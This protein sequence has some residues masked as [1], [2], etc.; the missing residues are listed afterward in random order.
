MR[1][2]NA[3]FQPLRDRNIGIVIHDER[4]QNV[5]H[6]HEDIPR[7]EAMA[8]KGKATHVCSG[9]E[10]SQAEV[11]NVISRVALA[12]RA[13]RERERILK[14]GTERRGECLQAEAGNV[15][16]K[17]ALAQRARRERERILKQGTTRL[18]PTPIGQI[19]P[20]DICSDDELNMP[21]GLGVPA[22]IQIDARRHYLGKM[23]IECPHCPDRI[24]TCAQVDNLVCAEFPNPSDDP[25][26]SKPSSLV[27]YMDHAVLEIQKQCVWKMESVL[28]DTLETSQNQLPW[29]KMVIPSIVVDT[30][31]K[32]LLEDDE[33]WVQCLEE[34][35]VIKIGYQLRRLFSVILTQCSPQ[36][37]MELWKRFWVHICDDLGHKIRTLFS[38]SNPTEAQIEDYGL[39]LLNQ[40]LQESGKSLLDFPPMQQPNANWSEVTG[41]RFIIEHRQLQIQAQ[42]IDSQPNIE[43]LN[44]GQR[45][46]YDAILT[47]VLDNKGTTFFMSGGAGTGKIFVHNTVA[48]KCRSFGHIVVT[49]AS[50]GIAFLLLEGGRTTH[51]TFCIPLDVY[52]NSGC[53]FSKQ[54]LQAELFRETKLII[55]DEVSMQHKHCVEAVDRTLQD[56][57][58]NEK[59]LGGITVVRPVLHVSSVVP[60]GVREDIVNASLR[61]SALWNDMR[62]LTLDLN[63]RL[64]IA[65]P[66][67]ATFA[68]FLMEVG[69]KPQEVVQLPTDIRKCQDL[70]EMLS[71]VYPQLN[72]SSTSTPT[73]LTERIILS[74]RN[75]DVNSINGAALN[76]YPGSVYT[77]LA[78][79]KMCED[80]EIDGSITN[81]YP[82]EYLNSLDPPGLP[83]FKLELKVGSP[84]ILLRNIA[85]KDGLCNG[86]RMMVVRC[87]SRI[88]ELIQPTEMLKLL[89][90]AIL[91]EFA[92][93][94]LD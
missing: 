38:I 55:W 29:M 92:I 46:A 26:L 47:S 34:A 10:N 41:N 51:S 60:K 71:A 54:S 9:K 80:D 89:G 13:R 19:H 73:F 42:R 83:P 53:G 23:D 16:S 4:D 69:T 90:T 93:C 70:N 17:V 35:A 22:P 77:Y 15:I 6:T 86:T 72:V 37:P 68:N 49:V 25:A 44:N 66:G 31:T 91:N 56:I 2:E 20:E 87:A 5:I 76:V 57:C 40:L 43:H 7:K 48:K 45:T 84:I 50:S 58:D 67:N 32:G 27:W 39:F 11:E 30:I 12:Q 21:T 28:R 59:I 75:D 82:N 3:Q 33:E 14:Q 79:D 94:I 36:K 1:N 78:A 65:C 88:I 24:R 64:N 85:P 61:C 62:V 8:R 63:M 74:A 52:D 18:G 81:R